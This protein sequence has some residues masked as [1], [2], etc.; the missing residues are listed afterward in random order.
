L[1]NILIVHKKSDFPVTIRIY[2]GADPRRAGTVCIDEN[3]IVIDFEEKPN[4]PKSDLGAGDIYIADSRI[5][6]V[7]PMTDEVATGKVLDLSYH[8]LPF[9][10]GHI[11][12]YDSGEYS[13]DIGTPSSY[14]KARKIYLQESTLTGHKFR[15]RGGAKKS[16]LK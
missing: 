10:A 11:K 6:D 8:V 12:A 3:D 1:L 16:G 14:E 5:F 2:K 13:I 15:L 7:F 9:M 4:Q